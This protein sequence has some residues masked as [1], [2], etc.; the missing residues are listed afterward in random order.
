MGV[1]SAAKVQDYSMKLYC[2]ENLLQIGNRFLFFFYGGEGDAGT[3]K[4]NYAVE[5]H[6]N[7]EY[8][9]SAPCKND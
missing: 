1:D 9:D 4:C 6:G 2:D 8:I 3:D 7:C 5:L